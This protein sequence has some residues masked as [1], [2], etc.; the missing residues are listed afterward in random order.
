MAIDVS[1]SFPRSPEGLLRIRVFIRNECSNVNSVGGGDGVGSLRSSISAAHSLWKPLFRQGAPL[2]YFPISQKVP[3][4]DLFT[5]PFLAVQ[6]F[7]VFV[8]SSFF[9]SFLLNTF[10]KVRKGTTRPPLSSIITI[11]TTVDQ[12]TGPFLD[13]LSRLRSKFQRKAQ[14]QHRKRI[15]VDQS[16][17]LGVLQRRV[18]A[19]KQIA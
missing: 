8:R 12:E 3:R 13:Q 15:E 9:S 6:E 7:R 18:G 17:K 1:W 10:Q 16:K 14:E 2:N 4:G 5:P 11:T 19:F